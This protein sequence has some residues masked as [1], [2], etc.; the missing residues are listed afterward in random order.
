MKRVEADEQWSLFDPKDVPEFVDLY[1]KDFEKK[2]K[3]AEEQGLAVRSLPA[4]KLY[5]RMM[6]T[7]AETGNG[8]MNFKDHSNKKSNQTLKSRKCD[9]F[10]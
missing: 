9:S 8:W 4:R 7:L 3:T 1:G 5:A 6:K 2:Y 10:V